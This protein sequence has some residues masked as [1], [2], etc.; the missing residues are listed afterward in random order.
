MTG[1]S[2]LT[3][4]PFATLEEYEACADFQEEIW[5]E[6]FS[7]KVSAA[8][9]MIA[10]RL[11]GVAA[12]AFDEEGI[13]HGF[14]FGLTGLLDGRPV[15]WSDMLAVRARGRDT[16]LGTRLKHYQ[17]RV[18]LD[19]GI[20][21]MR[22][23]FDPLQG[24][25]AHVNFSK[26]GITSR[27]Y[28]ENMYGETDSPLHKGVGTD[29]LVAIWAMDSERVKSRLGAGASASIPEGPGG[30]PYG[31]PPG[32]SLPEKVPG[33]IPFSVE[34]KFPSPGTPLLGLSDPRLLLP[35]PAV[36]DAIMAKD[37]PLAVR[38][39]EVTRE[40]FV[41]Y[42][43]RGYEVR[44]FIRGDEVSSYLLALTREPGTPGPT[45]PSTDK[46]RP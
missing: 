37:L 12:G 38:W 21:E 35:V 34:G 25:N 1:S 2:D 45:D 3:I 27:E 8:I 44:E 6:G 39:R 33:V 17:R 18:L 40:A 41:H 9:L 11:G 5:G 10:N 26:L 7:E 15:H 20:G 28:V 14:V 31:D 24:R 32:V 36:V 19:R 23:T 4:R 43:S 22:W 46:N 30:S 29:R 13:L 16:G 42:L